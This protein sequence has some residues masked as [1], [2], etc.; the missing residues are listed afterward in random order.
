[1]VALLGVAAITIDVGNWYV[2]RHQAQVAA[3]AASLAAA[4]CL[5]D[6]GTSGDACTSA[7]DTANATSVAN[8]IALAN[9]VTLVS[10]D[11]T[12]PSGQVSVTAPNPASGVFGGIFGFKSTNVSAKATASYTSPSTACSNP[13]SSCAAVFA[14]GSSCS[15]S[16]GDPGGSP[17]IFNGSGDT[18]QGIMH[19]NGSIYEAGGGNQTLGQTT[20]GNGSGCEIDTSN[21]TGDTWG[22]LS[23]MPTT[24]SAPTSTWPDD[25]TNVVTNCGSGYAYACTGP[26]GTPS[27][28]TNAAAN[29]TFGSGETTLT[30]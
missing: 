8:A 24:G 3:D 22:G 19:S 30:Q 20:F 5:A 27:Y 23:T 17:I 16:S 13:G 18:I 21:E 10:G 12:F 28:C 25:Y 7:T 9:G 6:A 15:N 11:V 29:Y 4:N 14:M 26:G 1:M 2:K